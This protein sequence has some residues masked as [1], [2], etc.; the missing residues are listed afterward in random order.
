MSIDIE[1]KSFILGLKQSGRNIHST[2]LRQIAD[3]F[4]AEDGSVEAVASSLNSRGRAD[5]ITN[6]PR[7]EMMKCA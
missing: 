2:T 6:R 5:N 3:L 7:V 1:D 4:L